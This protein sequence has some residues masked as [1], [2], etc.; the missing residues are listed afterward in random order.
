MIETRVNQHVD[1]MFYLDTRSEGQRKFKS[2]SRHP[3][4]EAAEHRAVILRNTSRPSSVKCS[5]GIGLNCLTCYPV[6][7]GNTNARKP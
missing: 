5:H 1:G 7:Y 4:R 3:S 6:Q 2:H